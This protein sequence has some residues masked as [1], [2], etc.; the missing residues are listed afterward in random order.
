MKFKYWLLQWEFLRS[1][2][3]FIMNEEKMVLEGEEHHTEFFQRSA[4]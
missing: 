3:L 4:R 2:D 1:S